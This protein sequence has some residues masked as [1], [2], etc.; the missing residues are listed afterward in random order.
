MINRVVAVSYHFLLELILGLLFLFFFYID[1]KE[2]PPILL[3]VA[4][5]LGGLI[6]LDILLE[7]WMNKGKWLFFVIVFPLILVTGTKAGFSIYVVAVLGLFIF[8]RGISL[9]GDFTGHS[10][11]LFLFLSFL[12][13]MIVIIYSAM[14]HYP[15]QSWI[16]SLLLLQIVLVLAGLFFSK[17]NMIAEDKMRFAL[18]YLKMIGG[19]LIISVV[20]TFFMKYIQLLFFGI[21]KMIVFLFANLAALGLNII[22][23]LLSLFGKGEMIP[24]SLHSDVEHTV[25]KYKGDAC[26]M[27]SNLM[28]ILLL[29]VAVVFTI[30]FLYKKRLNLLLGASNHS[31]LV[32]ISEGGLR[33][34]RSS[35]FKKRTKPPEDFIRR[36]IFQLEKYAQ[37][38][39]LGRLPYETLDEWLQR[40]GLTE[41][42]QVNEVYQKIRYGTFLSSTEE[43]A[44]V[45][46]KI[47]Y[48]KQQIREIA[49]SKK[50]KRE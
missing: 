9:Y 26:F 5:C 36:Q 37:M 49:K 19:I 20:I 35:I 11:T 6:S 28:Y 15:Y 14:I 50:D 17:W 33:Q 2:L 47:H 31:S 45:K 38:L 42:G 4:L 39:K 10:E 3:L 44:Q 43:Q 46:A 1:S 41:T 34:G 25:G 48:L 23:F 8:W 7:K 13:G 32:E 24:Q 21:L 16:V 29:L 22:E 18:Y 27:T 40:V 12:L 30:Y